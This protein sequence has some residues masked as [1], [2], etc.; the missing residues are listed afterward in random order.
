MLRA[1]M[2]PY[3]Y[4]KHNEKILF[5]SFYLTHLIA[6]IEN[7]SNLDCEIIDQIFSMSALWLF[8]ARLFAGGEGAVLGIVGCLTASD[9]S[10]TPPQV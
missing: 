5:E 2:N 8:G 3:L 10:R 7:K 1:D 6:I 9:A 4:L